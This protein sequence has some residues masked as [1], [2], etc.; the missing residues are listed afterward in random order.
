MGA[1]IDD[2]V[3]AGNPGRLVG[4]KVEDRLRG[5]FGEID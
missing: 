5:V 1:A 3:R 4:G 2:E